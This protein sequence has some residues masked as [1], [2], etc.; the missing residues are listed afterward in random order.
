MRSQ[1]SDRPRKDAHLAVTTLRIDRDELATF[2][3]IARANDRTVTQEL[4]RVIKRHI[5]ENTE[6]EAA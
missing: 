6:Q 4:R 2:R 1:D 3:A 5:R